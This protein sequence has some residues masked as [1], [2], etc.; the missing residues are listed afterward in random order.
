LFQPSGSPPVQR[1]R[2]RTPRHRFLF[3]IKGGNI[4]PFSATISTA[5]EVMVTYG[6]TRST[7]P[8]LSIATVEGLATLAR[9]ERF[10][11]LPAKISCGEV[12]ADIGIEFISIRTAHKAKTVSDRGC[13]NR[14][15]DELYAV[16]TAVV[17]PIVPPG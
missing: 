5:G 4:I 17:P 1:A 12:P 15:L 2:Q 10:F 14:R 8:R 11:A 16:L 3:G 6:L 7:R 9:A 13:P